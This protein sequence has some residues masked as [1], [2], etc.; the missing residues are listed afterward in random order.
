MARRSESLALELG[1][2]LFEERAESFFGVRHRE[3]AVLQ[4]P[5]EGEA[6]VHR[7]L[8]PFRH[9][10]LDEPDCPAGM[11]RIGE[12]FR[13]GHRLVPEL[14]PREHAVEQAPV[15]GVFRG[16]HAPRRHEVDRSTLPADPGTSLDA[17]A[18]KRD[19]E[20]D[21]RYSD[22]PSAI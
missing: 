15:E 20:G 2:P 12:P 3:E 5:L 8:R 4:L 9:G 19:T 13:E 16:D 17:Y 7:H 11:L 1:R 10:P 14:R 18:S 21:L 6:L 22:P